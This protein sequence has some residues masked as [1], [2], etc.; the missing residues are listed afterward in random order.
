MVLADF[1]ELRDTMSKVSLAYDFDDEL[2]WMIGRSSI[3]RSVEKMQVFH[4]RSDHRRPKSVA[5]ADVDPDGTAG[6]SSH[7][8]T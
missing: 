8:R 3:R 6:N 1:R 2:G 7:G 5:A 4:A